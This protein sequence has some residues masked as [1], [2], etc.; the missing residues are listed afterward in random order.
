MLKIKAKYLINPAVFVL[1]VFFSGCQ[2]K[3]SSPVIVRIGKSVLT[4]EDL[5]K[6]IPP[7]YADRISPEQNVNYVKQWIQT[8]LLYREALRLKYDKEAHIQERLEKMKKDLL[9]A[10]VI[11]RSSKHFSNSIEQTSITD[12]Y[13]QNQNKF[14]RDKDMVI[15][16]EIVVEDLKTAYLIKQNANLHNF[17]EYAE[18]YSKIPFSDTLNVTPVP[19]DDVPA[20]LKSAIQA[21]MPGNISNPIKSGIGYQL[22][23]IIEKLPKGSICREEEVREE[24]LTILSAKKQKENIEKMISSLRLKNDMEY[25]M[26][27]ITGNNSDSLINNQ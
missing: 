24:I 11:N 27:L 4:V 20:D 23:L 7:E 1:S 18:K 17:S 10:E 12:Y 14:I 21:T 19:V 13:T 22:L 3:S 8:E 9:A 26:N 15:Y 25:N 2:E 5:Y 6:S 16:L